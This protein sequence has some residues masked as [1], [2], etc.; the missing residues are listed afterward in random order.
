M[1]KETEIKIWK[2]ITLILLFSGAIILVMANS[3]LQSKLIDATGM[4]WMSSMALALTSLGLGSFAIVKTLFSD[5]RL[6]D[7][8]KKEVI[9]KLSNF[10]ITNEHNIKLIQ[11]LIKHKNNWFPQK[12]LDKKLKQP[13]SQKYK[14]TLGE[15]K[16]IKGL[17]I[18]KENFFYDY[19]VHLL[20]ISQHLDNIFVEKIIEYVNVGRKLNEHKENCQHWALN[21][22]VPNPDE[23]NSY[24]TALN[25]AK[26][27]TDEMKDM[28][29]QQIQEIKSKKIQDRTYR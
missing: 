24:Y 27:I 23:T 21:R 5:K 13:K 7:K 9:S 8:E 1:K 28:I 20:D 6:A 16:Q 3:L 11:N 19:A 15:L 4:Q 22:G 10:S 12:L 25:K 2:T 29:N 14:L 26:E 17:W 18:P